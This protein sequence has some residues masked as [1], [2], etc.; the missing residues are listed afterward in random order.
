MKNNANVT[1]T[2]VL[3]VMLLSISFWFMKTEIKSASGVNVNSE[4]NIHPYPNAETVNNRTIDDNVLK[5]KNETDGVIAKLKIIEEK[6][7]AIS[8]QLVRI[9]KTLNIKD[10]LP[11]PPPP[12]TYK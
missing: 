2:A 4:R 7:D 6:I 8:E 11:V 9:E 1:K 5:I 10:D 12:E 3:L